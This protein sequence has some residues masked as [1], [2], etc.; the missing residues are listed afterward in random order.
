VLKALK[1]AST[2]ARPRSL[3]VLPV[4]ELAGLLCFLLLPLFLDLFGMVFVTRIIIL[5]IFAISFDLVWGYAG[6]LS[7]GQAL[8]FGGGAYGVALLGRDL[9]WAQ[10]IVTLPLAAMIGGVLAILLAWFLLL[11]RRS[12]SVVFVSLGTLTGSYAAERLVNASEYLGGRN[13]ISG[14]PLLRMGN[15]EFL[16]GLPFYFLA[17]GILVLVYVGC[18][19]VVRSQFGLVLAGMRDQ[20]RRLLFLGYHVPRFKLLI[21]TASGLIAG[22][23]GGLYA[24]HEGYAGPTSLGM[25]LSTLVVLYAL[26]G[27]TGTLAGAVIGVIVIELLSLV[28]SDMSPQFWS[29]ML[30]IVLLAVIVFQRSGIVGFLMT[31]R[32]RISRFGRPS[33]RA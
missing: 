15:F 10:A 3:A 1:N 27:G 24:Y 33:E 26:L 29:M 19:I 20:E 30:G 31:E 25:Q 22:L 4:L 28:L 5:A 16:E 21:F 18:R 23:A 11:G 13:G 8:F 9:N 17:L 12:S 6:I 14:I 2:T 32:D 7:F